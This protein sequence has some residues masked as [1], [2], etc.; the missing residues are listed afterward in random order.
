MINEKQIIFYLGVISLIICTGFLVFSDI[1]RKP[2]D[3]QKFEKITST[4][5][6]PPEVRKMRD[7]NIIRFFLEGIENEFKITGRTY[8]AICKTKFLNNAQT[9][10]EIEV[11]VVKS[12]IEKLNNTSLIDSH[13]FVRQIKIGTEKYINRELSNRLQWAENIFIL[14]LYPFGFLLIIHSKL[15]KPKIGIWTSIVVLLIIAVCIHLSHLTWIYSDSDKKTIC[16]S[17]E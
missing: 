7:G 11:F 2:Q 3:E 13:I 1:I 9:G 10:V 16:Q 8:D 15:D 5:T 14:F 12:E 4:I 6:E 17:I